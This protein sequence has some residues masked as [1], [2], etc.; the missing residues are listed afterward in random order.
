MNVETGGAEMAFTTVEL[1]QAEAELDSDV[2]RD[3]LF[4]LGLICST[5][6]EDRGP[7]FVS[8]HKWFNL[9]AMMGSQPAKAYRDEVGYEM[10]SE[11]ITQAQREARE[12]LGKN[13][14]LLVKEAA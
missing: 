8:A 6:I 2:T 12:W 5:E 1:E 4:K 9:A 10:S 11:E 3:D 7:D 13:R 14:Q